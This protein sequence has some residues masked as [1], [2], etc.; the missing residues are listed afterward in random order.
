MPV[1]WPIPTNCES[2]PQPHKRAP[3]W[4]CRRPLPLFSIC[5]NR[6]AV[7]G[8]TVDLVRAFA[9]A[10]NR[11]TANHHKAAALL[12]ISIFLHSPCLLSGV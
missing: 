6:G 11:N 12:A 10:L 2:L 1:T 5:D 8:V 3:A 9:A 4:W 7:K